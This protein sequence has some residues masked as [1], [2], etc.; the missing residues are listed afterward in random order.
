MDEKKNRPDNSQFRQ[1]RLPAWQPVMSPPH[2]SACLTFLAV[3]FI[4]I[5]I[6]I[7]IANNSI[8]EYEVRYDD[9]RRCTP[10]NNDGLM[11]VNLA[12]RSY[13]QGCRTIVNFTV[14]AD[15]PGPVYMYYKL[16]NFYQN[17]RRYAKSRDTQQIAGKDVGTPSSDCEPLLTPGDYWGN[18]S[19]PLTVDGTAM[20]YAGL[21]YAPCGLVAWSMFN[22]TFKLYSTT[23]GGTPT[24]LCDTSAFSKETNQPTRVNMTCTKRGVTWESDY[25]KFAKPFLAPNVWTGNRSAYG[26]SITTNDPFLQNGYYAFEAGH[27]VPTT[28]DE[29]FMVWMRTASLPTFRKLFRI[30]SRGIRAGSYSMEINEFFDSQQ[31]DGTK[32]FVLSTVSW[33]GAKNNFLGLAYIIVGSVC[34][35]C[36]IIFFIV[37]KVTGDR[38]QAAIEVLGE[39]R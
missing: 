14:A 34:M 31:Y 24:L 29:D 11:T 17:H 33:V 2:V 15:V 19:A 16:T 21:K 23:G 30:F 27:V 38:T 9:V 28:T 7:I 8:F 1:Q 26:S 36:A 13:S 10:N 5:G 39:L 12:G 20:T 25:Q 18:T 32:S 6:A 3:V 37:H 4:P 35:L 22:D